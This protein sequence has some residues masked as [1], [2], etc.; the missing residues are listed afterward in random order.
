MTFPSTPRL[1]IFP[2]AATIRIALLLAP[3]LATM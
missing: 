1:S 2:T 3:L